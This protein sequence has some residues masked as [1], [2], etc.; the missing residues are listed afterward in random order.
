MEDYYLNF[1]FY[2]H[3][4]NDINKWAEETEEHAVTCFINKQDCDFKD[5][6]EISRTADYAQSILEDH[7]TV[8]DAIDVAIMMHKLNLIEGDTNE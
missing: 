2:P 8:Q 3:R 6:G 7:D 4:H 5:I 1:M